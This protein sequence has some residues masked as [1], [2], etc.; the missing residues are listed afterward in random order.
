MVKVF[1][2]IPDVA[3]E[4]T[5]NSW[6]TTL[7]EDYEVYDCKITSAYDPST[8]DV[9]VNA[10]FFYRKVKSIT[11]NGDFQKE[12]IKYEAYKADEDF[13]NQF[14]KQQ[15]KNYGE[16]QKEL[17]KSKYRSIVESNF[18]GLRDTIAELFEFLEKEEDKSEPYARGKMR[19]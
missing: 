10:V 2:A 1:G 12:K 5:V 8:Q 9:D 19:R 18:G 17:E 11:D 4:G 16:K 13:L 7:G 6:L 15:F 14:K 3:F